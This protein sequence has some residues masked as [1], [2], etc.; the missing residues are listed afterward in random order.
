MWR[1]WSTQHTGR[2]ARGRRM[3]MRAL[4]GTPMSGR[5]ETGPGV[6][7]GSGEGRCDQGEGWEGL[8]DEPPDS[9]HSD[10]G[11]DSCPVRHRGFLT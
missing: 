10:T 6:R 9:T 5:N 3:S 8:W 11:F 1:R 7:G 2:S 4:P